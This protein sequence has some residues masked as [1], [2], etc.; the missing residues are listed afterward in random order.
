VCAACGK[1]AKDRY[2]I[3]GEHSFGWDESCALNA[4]LCHEEKSMTRGGLAQLPNHTRGE[5]K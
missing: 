1:T 3:E 4:V 5:V 2:G